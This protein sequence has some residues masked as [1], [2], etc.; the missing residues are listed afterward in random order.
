MSN[1]VSAHL[2][3]MHLM[4]AKSYDPIPP[5][6]FLCFLDKDVRLTPTGH[7][8]HAWLQ[9]KTI[10]SPGGS[11]HRTPQAR[12]TR[13]DLHLAEMAPDLGIDLPAASRAWDEL[14]REGIGRRDEKGRLW[15]CGKVQKTEGRNKSEETKD[16]LCTYK[17]PERFRLYLQTLDE[18]QRAQ[19]EQRY[20]L[21]ARFGE[22]LEA[23]AIK[24]ARAAKQEVVAEVF[25][26]AG[27]IDDEERG[28][29]PK[30]RE[31]V[32][33]LALAC[34][35]ADFCVHTSVPNSVQ[36]EN[37]QVYANG[38]GN[39]HNS[40]SLVPSEQSSKVSKEAP[41]DGR[42]PDSSLPPPTTPRTKERKN[43]PGERLVPPKGSE[44]DNTVRSLMGAAP[45]ED[46]SLLFADIAERYGLPVRSVCRLLIDK[47]E[48]KKRAHYPISS[49]RALYQMIGKNDVRVWIAQNGENIDQDRRREQSG[50]P[51]AVLAAGFVS[52]EAEIE[53]RERWIADFPD[54]PDTAKARK[55]LA[56]LR[57]QSGQRAH[58]AGG[59]G[60][61]GGAA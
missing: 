2:K 42:G 29:P 27:F 8:A 18:K 57:A 10:H 34:T 28:R 39:V 50:N 19:G 30:N 35:F 52:A 11:R 46:E 45:T 41:E 40:A 1:T 15:M 13:G 48:S 7:R 53:F 47:V 22:Q 5:D 49:V 9:S 60:G 12:D 61:G 31:L 55:R 23:D 3:L 20:F 59:A 14:E 58:G 51:E 33:K 24:A 4:G 54:H 56:E 25:R 6:Q 32:V 36:S 21:A 43:P 38:N 16:E 26:E 44:I 17:L 37:G